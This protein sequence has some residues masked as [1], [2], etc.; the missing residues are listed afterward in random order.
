VSGQI[1]VP[2]AFLALVSGL[3]LVQKRQ[4]RAVKNL[5]INKFMACSISLRRRRS[6]SATR[7]LTFT[8]LY[9]IISQNIKLFM[10][11]VI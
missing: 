1:S 5:L 6:L 4:F 3:E 7:R 2:A 9:D 8:G 10:V 11:T